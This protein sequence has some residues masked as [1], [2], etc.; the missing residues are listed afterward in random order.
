[1]S[2]YG[3][4]PYVP[5]A[6]RREKALKEAQKAQKNGKALNPV[7]IEGRKIA[8][9]VWG[10]AWCDNLESY[11]DYENRLPRGRTYVRSGAIIDLVIDPGKVR[12]QVMGSSLY[13]IEI[14]VAPR[15]EGA[16][17]KAGG[18]SH[19]LHRL[20]R[21][22]SAGEA[23]E[24]GDGKDLPPRL[25]PL[26]LSP[27][28][29]PLLLLSRL[30]LDVQTCGRGALWCRSAPRLLPR[31]TLYPPKCLSLRPDCRGRQGPFGLEE[32]SGEGPGS[33]SRRAR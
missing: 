2:Y 15:R 1:M 11:S 14:T 20:S 5:V 22:A 29:R 19:R 31:T 30:G 9:T 10:Q 8:K 28:D 16:L 25:G 27:G 17:G 12:A 21:R 3:F 33:R 13:R 26:P 18:G 7:H 6:K 4:R 23:V 24:R 32:G